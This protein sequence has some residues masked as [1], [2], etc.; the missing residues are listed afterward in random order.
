MK[1]N[2][3]SFVLRPLSSVLRPSSFVFLL[4]LC[5]FALA[6]L[7]APGYFSRAH[8]ARHSVYFLQ[9][10]DATFRDGAWYPRW[11]ADMVFGYGYPLWLILA[12]IPFFVGEA[13]HLIGFDLVSAVKIVDGLAVFC[14]ALTMYLFASRVLGT[15][16]GLVAAVTYV[17]VPYHLV[18]L[19]VR[20]AQAELVAFVFPP[21][22][23]W[24]FYELMTTRRVHYIPLAAL[25]Y[26][27]L[28]LA[29]ISV[30]VIFT[31]IIGVYV[32]FLLLTT[33]RPPAS[34]LLPPA[35]CLLPPA[36]CLL[37]P[38]LSILLAL[39]ISAIFWL[40]V[41]FEQRYLT[42]DPLIGGFFN[43]RKHFLNAHQLFSPF[44]GYG[45]AGEYGTSQFSLQLGLVPTLLAFVA[46]FAPARDALRAHILFFAGIV[47]A[48]TFAML[49]ISA[50]LWE[51]FATIVAFVQFP[52]RLLIVTA[53]AL[54]FLAGAA[55]HAFAE[56]D[57]RAA[58]FALVLL[59]LSAS[60]PYTQP[61]H[62]EALFTPQTLMEFQLQEGELL[63]DTVWLRGERPKDSP[64]V[65]QYLNGEPLRKA[66]AL[67]EHARVAT[68]RYGGNS[69]VLHVESDT[70]ARVLVYTRYFP[71]WTARIHQQH[72]AI[73]PYGEQ[74]LI[75]VH[76]PA[77]SHIV[78][79][80]FEDT[81]I[82]RI[83]ALVSFLTLLVTLGWLGWH[84]Q[85]R[86]G[87]V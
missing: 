87:L 41:L 44:W 13:F 43:Y 28:I 48:M 1:N 75:L 61:Q 69:T 20:A 39:G 76:V 4:A 33:R 8:D 78:T 84:W 17:Y 57:T 9:M 38:A 73:E 49:P 58:L 22:I 63:G 21:L 45:Y 56:H 25:A 60:Y 59:L 66:V 40:P 55:L 29:H 36:S 70:S 51:P 62:T 35:S 74:G 27:G 31:P 23:F 15:R 18:D 50:P 46:L 26:A 83:G 19:Y 77:G 79:L 64:L 52:W 72:L 54:A 71:G 34:C 7:T 65:E 5:V 6:P 37:P 47:V 82:R 24:A 86:K 30:A 10:F 80:R 14:S 68:V 2:L 32:L 11:A 53:F 67:D 85:N 16:A 12:P 81:P 3:S 42:S